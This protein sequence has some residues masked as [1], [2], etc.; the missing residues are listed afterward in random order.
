M[1]ILKLLPTFPIRRYSLEDA[2]SQQFEI[3]ATSGLIGRSREDVAIDN[4]PVTVTVRVAEVAGEQRSATQQLTVALYAL[5]PAE[6]G[7]GVNPITYD[8]TIPV[9]AAPGSEVMR[10]PH[11]QGAIIRRGDPTG[12]F[13]LVGQSLRV[14][15]RL[16]GNTTRELRIGRADTASSTIV[17]LVLSEE[18]AA[19]FVADTVTV[20]V[21][22]GAWTDVVILD[23][24]RY[25]RGGKAVCSGGVRC[26]FSVEG[27][28]E[29]RVYSS[30]GEVRGVGG[31]RSLAA[32]SFAVVL[33]SR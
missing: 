17:R 11:H 18:R 28:S 1:A 2:G 20:A 21:Y 16:Y 4:F 22:E 23:A 13:E 19:T 25:V 29:A 30:G 3:N 27:T 33:R 24:G 12:Q 7:G 32:T 15:H 6:E 31:L 10:L 5:P 9:S 14:R 26:E 8:V